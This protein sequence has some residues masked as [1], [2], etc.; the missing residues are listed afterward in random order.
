MTPPSLFEL[1]CRRRSAWRRGRIPPIGVFMLDAS[2]LALDPELAAV[3]GAEI[4][5][6]G[7]GVILALVQAVGSLRPIPLNGPSAIRAGARR[8]KRIALPWPL[9]PGVLVVPNAW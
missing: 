2:V 4:D 9:V 3:P 8:S 1:Q 6:A 7:D 5:A